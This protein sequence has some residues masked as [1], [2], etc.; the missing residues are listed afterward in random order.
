MKQSK[1]GAK[2][3]D[4]KAV[5]THQDYLKSGNGHVDIA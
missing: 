4:S 5:P 1:V 3:D 2:Q